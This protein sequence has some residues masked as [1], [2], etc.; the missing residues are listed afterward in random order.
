M[1]IFSISDEYRPVKI[2]KVILGYQCSASMGYF[3]FDMNLNYRLGDLIKRYAEDKPTLIF[4]STRKGSEIAASVL[5]KNPPITMKEDRKLYLETASNQIED[6]KL[7]PFFRAG[8]IYHHAGIS[9]HDRIFFEQEFRAG[10]V[11]IMFCTSTL[12][13]GINLPAHLVI[14]KT[15][16][17]YGDNG[18][19]EEYPESSIFQM[20]GRA[21]RPQFD[22]SGVAIIMTQMQNV[23]S[24][25]TQINFIHKYRHKKA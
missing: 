24:F 15:T 18:D 25:Y 19:N 10:N 5:M 2:E 13:M 9:R 23:V 4:C 3:R 12:A 14:I 8:I 16:Q 22:T 17:M 7:R 1:L 11:P 6:A 20:I 21:G